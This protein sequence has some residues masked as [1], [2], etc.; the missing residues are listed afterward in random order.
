MVEETESRSMT[1]DLPG[2]PLVVVGYPGDLRGHP[3]QQVV[4]EQVLDA[5][6]V[7][8]SFQLETCEVRLSLKHENIKY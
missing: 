5:H 1:A 8:A 3:L 6:V 7:K 4:N 2:G